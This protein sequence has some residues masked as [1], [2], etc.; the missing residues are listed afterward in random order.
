MLPTGLCHRSVIA[1]YDFWPGWGWASSARNPPGFLQI[2]PKRVRTSRSDI[3][4]VLE[5]PRRDTIAIEIQ[6]TLS[7]TLSKG[8]RLRFEDIAASKGLDVIPAGS[9]FP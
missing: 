2:L 3:Y 5:G 7:P 9:K 4:L 1:S 6:R 8:I